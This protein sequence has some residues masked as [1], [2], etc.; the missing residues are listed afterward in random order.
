LQVALERQEC[1][2]V[3]QP[4]VDLASGRIEGIEALLR[5]EHPTRGLLAPEE[6]LEVA[7]DA[8]L[9]V[10]IG[11]WVL[12]EAC[13]QLAR[14]EQAHPQAAD[15]SISVNVAAQQVRRKGFGDEVR[16][17]ITE[18]R[19]APER[20]VLELTENSLLDAELSPVIEQLHDIG[21]RIAI[22]DFG[23]GYSSMSYL[24]RFAVDEVKI[25]RT[26]VAG[27]G[28]DPDDEVIL[29]AVVEMSR[30]LGLDTVAEGV[31]F[32]GQRDALL[33]LGCRR[34]QGYL[35]G[36]PCDPEEIDAILES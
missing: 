26:F 18:A 6:F 7:E 5:W 33:A 24:K 19:I 4:I 31:E 35:F 20:V 10:P 25:D 22:D 2:L 21:V 12:H 1:R 9:L 15:L 3:Y 32:P 14:W 8:G 17:A 16:A 36:K 30:N 29:S 28:R 34:G 23:T 13:A 27:L 11:G